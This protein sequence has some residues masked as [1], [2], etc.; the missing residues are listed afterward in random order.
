MLVLNKNTYLGNIANAYQSEDFC[1]GRVCYNQ[2]IFFSEMHC[3]ENPHLSLVV[4]GGNIEKRRNISFER[5]PGKVTFYHP[6]EAH[7]NSYQV[8]CSS[9]INIEVALSWLQRQSL[10]IKDHCKFY[11][12]ASILILKMYKES[13]TGDDFSSDAIK[14]LLFE[15]LVCNKQETLHKPSWID[16]LEE[17]LNDRW[18]ETPALQDLSNAA[19]VH[20]ITISKH[21]S[22]YFGCTLGEYMR[23]LK[24]TRAISLMNTSQTSLTGI[25]YECGFADQSHFTRT[26]KQLTGLLPKEYLRL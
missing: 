2:D 16:T 14:L 13:L 17:L 1:I 8:A 23:K 19:G 18:N 7:Q 24:I 15:L 6:G 22:R 11:P 25:A 3:H 20:P 4:S 26:F 5:L 10:N 9:H 21:F 12:G